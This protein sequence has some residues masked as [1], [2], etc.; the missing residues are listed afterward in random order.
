MAK[1][2]ELGSDGA[3]MPTWVS[4]SEAETCACDRVSFPLSPLLY[5]WDDN[6]SS[7]RLGIHGKILNRWPFPSLSPFRLTNYPRVLSIP[8]HILFYGT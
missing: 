8:Q 1:F 6:T 7:L 3:Q 5:I 4:S 2:T